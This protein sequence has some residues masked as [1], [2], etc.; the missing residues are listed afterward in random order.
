MYRKKYLTFLFS[1][2]LFLA[3]SIAA[4]AQTGPVRGEV[5]LQKADGT[6]VPVADAVIDV[7]RTDIDKGGRP[8]G[9]TNSKG[10]F[11]F[12]GFPLGQ[13]FVI[14]VSG[15]GIG[16]RVQPDIKAGMESIVITVNEGDGRKLTEA[17]VR[18]VVASAA[19]APSGEMS[20][21]DK[22]ARAEV[23]KKNAE[24]MEK[25]KRIQE[26]DSIA[27]KSNTEG[28]AA[29]KAKNYDLA[30]Q[31]FGEG[32]AAVPD[33]IGST[34][35]NLNGLLVSYRGKGYDIYREGA[36]SPDVAAR[37][38]KYEA[39]NKEYNAA[40][41]A[42]EKAL[43]VFKN[44]EATTDPAE[45]KRRDSLKLE[46]Y[47]NAVEVHRL[48]AAGGVDT[49][50]G[51]KAETVLTEYIAMETDPAKKAAAQ[52]TLGDVMRETGNFDKAVAAYKAVLAA[53]PENMDATAQLG[54][55]LV[56]LGTSVDPPNKEQLQE[57]LN[58]MQKFAD[59]AP[60]THKYK[61]DVK[62]MVEYLKT[63]QKLTPQKTT[64]RRK[65]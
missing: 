18:E 54:L 44:A 25:N 36:T 15:T 2:A 21:A 65:N 61:N 23:E 60:D 48:K 16:P 13:R 35:V 28:V 39:A 57:G 62:Q 37:K 50:M 56:A 31:K 10:E 7:Y 19:G 30:I 58:Y 49:S 11:A 29:L 4:F 32:V 43:A 47:S 8:S 41:D 20:E 45:Q 46:L 53:S 1:A 42:F 59:A 26:S 63:E 3:G 9:K 52:L 51:D 5:K 17:E 24:I 27:S 38:A 33:F 64:G 12:I 55:T 22:K 40:L 34:P 14:A 6:T